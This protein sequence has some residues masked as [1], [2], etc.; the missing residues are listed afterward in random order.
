MNVAL[1]VANGIA[2]EIRSWGLWHCSVYVFVDRPVG[3]LV[4][5]SDSPLQYAYCSIRVIDDRVWFRLS[6]ILNYG[7]EFVAS[8]PVGDPLEVV[9]P[10]CDPCL[11]E[12]LERLV[13][14]AVRRWLVVREW[15]R[16]RE[17]EASRVRRSG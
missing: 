6:G 3:A 4:L 1:A 17:M 15:A 10:L 11:L 8:D 7:D 5:I 14:D 9:L 12:R 16:R 2:D 13:R